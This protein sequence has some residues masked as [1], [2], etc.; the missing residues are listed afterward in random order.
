LCRRAAHRVSYPWNLVAK[1]AGRDTASYGH[2]AE[3]LV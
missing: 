2:A 3:V 1:M